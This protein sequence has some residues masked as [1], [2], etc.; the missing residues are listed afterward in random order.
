[1]SKKSQPQAPAPVDPSVAI[2]A[3]ADVNRVDQF[4]PWANLTFG[5]PDRRE[6]TL[7]LDPAVQALADQQISADT[8]LLGLANQAIGP[9]GIS[10]LIGDPLSTEG[11]PGLPQDFN[12]YRDDAERAFFDRTQGLLDEQFQIEDDRLRQRLANQGFQSGNE[13]WNQEMGLFNQRRGD[14]FS[15]LANDA[16][17][18]GG[19]EASRALAGQAGLRNTAFSEMGATRA[20]QFN[21]LASLLGLQQ[22][23]QPGMQNFFGPG[24]VDALGAYGLQQQGLQNNYNTR[25]Q[26][27]SQAKGATASLIGSLGGGALAGR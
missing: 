16:V 24:Q 13:A 20:N 6:A 17:L 1:M 18:F 14:A 27:A 15:N 2:E 5:G 12:A 19:Q 26:A 4:T 22:V 21:E 3:Q 9:G 25:S 8:G 10:D 11:L 23:Q 7:T